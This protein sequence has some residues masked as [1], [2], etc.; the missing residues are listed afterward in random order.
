MNDTYYGR[1]TKCGYGPY[2]PS[3]SIPCPRCGKKMSDPIFPV[4]KPEIY[5]Y[6]PKISVNQSLLN[7][8][9]VCLGTG[10]NTLT[11]LKC[12]ICNGLGCF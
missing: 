12:S 10:K 4:N 9:L 1:C 7:K 8:C 2:S 3:V 5:I 6:K 11:G